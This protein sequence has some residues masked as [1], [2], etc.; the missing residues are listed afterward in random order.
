MR[1]RAKMLRPAFV[2]NESIVA[3]ARR[4]VGWV[5]S[6]EEI[7]VVNSRAFAVLLSEWTEGS[8]DAVEH[9]GADVMT[10]LSA[11]APR[12]ASARVLSFPGR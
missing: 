5:W 9:H 12:T 7:D 10:E 1:L 11:P 8:A 2:A 4:E 3:V 6:K